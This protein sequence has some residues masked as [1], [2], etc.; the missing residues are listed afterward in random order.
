MVNISKKKIDNYVLDRLFELLFVV[1]S[2][3]RKESDFRNLFISLFSNTER[4][5]I[6]KR[7]GLIYLMLKNFKKNDI[8]RLIKI[9]KATFDKYKLIIDKDPIIYE[10]FKSFI[11]KEK[12]INIF[13]E[14]INI[15]YGPG[16]PGVNWT[17]ALKTKRKIEIRKKYGF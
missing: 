16:T 6:V 10:K 11:K 3:N 1:F 9:S 14:I 12:A 8:C 13:E 2:E 4:I 17:D 7:L 5:M 15:L